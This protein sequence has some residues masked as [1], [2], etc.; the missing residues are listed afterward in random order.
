M[1]SLPGLKPGYTEFGIL[2]FIRLIYRLVMEV[3]SRLEREYRNLGNFRV[4]RLRY[5]TEM[6]D[7][8]GLEPTSSPLEGEDS[9]PLSYESKLITKVIIAHFSCLV[10]INLVPLAWIRTC[11]LLLKGELL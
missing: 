5:R 3:L 6:E 1:E 4:I 8:V 10:K 7:P 2:G 9:N 11:G